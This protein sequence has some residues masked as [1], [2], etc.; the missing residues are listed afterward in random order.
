VLKKKY[1][2]MYLY[3]HK[4]LGDVFQGTSNSD[5]FWEEKLGRSRKENYFC[6]AYTLELFD[7]DPLVHEK[8]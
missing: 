6:I 2:Y 5:Y 8:T 3:A 7:L 1:K 4:T